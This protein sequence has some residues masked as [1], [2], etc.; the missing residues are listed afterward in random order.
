MF[1]INFFKKNYCVDVKIYIILMYFQVKN[2]FYHSLKQVLNIINKRVLF[3][4]PIKFHD[5]AMEN[6]TSI[7]YTFK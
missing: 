1:Q 4:L 5:L 6:I 7:F 3:N 2:I